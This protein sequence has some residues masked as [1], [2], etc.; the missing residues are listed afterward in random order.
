MQEITEEQLKELIEE[1]KQE[2]KDVSKLEE[3]L[4]LMAEGALES[5]VDLETPAV[6]MMGEKAERKEGEKKV[7]IESTG[8]AREED[9]E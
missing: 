1:A 7:I 9:F 8:P 5:A 4:N 3:Q 2:G 6:P